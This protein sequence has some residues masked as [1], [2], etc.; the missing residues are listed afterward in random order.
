MIFILII[1]I[2]ILFLIIFKYRENLGSM[3]PNKYLIFIDMEYLAKRN[4]MADLLF[5]FMDNNYRTARIFLGSQKIDCILF[6]SNKGNIYYKSR[7]ESVYPNHLKYHF[8]KTKKQIKKLVKGKSI[9]YLAKKE[10]M[11]SMN[12][13]NRLLN[14]EEQLKYYSY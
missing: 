1:L 11:E 5:R 7:L 6:N 13:E 10:F 8:P 4:D 14:A 3:A 12:L 9:L 2:I